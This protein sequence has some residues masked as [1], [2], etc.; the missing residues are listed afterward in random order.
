MWAQGYGCVNLFPV[1]SG[2]SFSRLAHIH[3]LATSNHCI[4]Y[5]HRIKTRIDGL[6][7][8]VKLGVIIMPI[9]QHSIHLQSLAHYQGQDGILQDYLFKKK[10]SQKIRF[11]LFYTYIY[12]S[13]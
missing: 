12:K 5:I 9:P 4:L 13:L 6:N 3:F 10:S 2:F 8:N 11:I 7:Y 1:S